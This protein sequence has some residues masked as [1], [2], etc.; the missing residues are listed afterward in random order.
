MKQI[1]PCNRKMYGV[2]RERDGHLIRIPVLGFGID[3]R[4]D[5]VPLVFD[6]YSGIEPEYGCD[7][8]VSF[9]L[10]S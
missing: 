10:E 2:Y 3:N 6:G 4:G 9:S 7:N 8:F 5:I 1:I